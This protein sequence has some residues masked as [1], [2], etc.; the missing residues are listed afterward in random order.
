MGTPLISVAEAEASG[1]SWDQLQT[2]RWRR[3]G[4]GQYAPT[5]VKDGPLLRLTAVAKRLPRGAAFAG[6][7]AAWLH[8]IDLPPCDP[9]EVATPEHIGLSTRSGVI[10]RRL[11]LAP[12]EIV[13]CRGFPTTTILRTLTDLAWRLPLIDAVAAI[14][15]ALHAGLVHISSLNER[16]IALGGRKGVRRLRR[17]VDLAEPR[18]ESPMETR[19]RLVLVLGGLPRPEAQVDLKS[20]AGDF[21]GRA[22]LYYADARLILEFDG[23]THKTSLVEDSRRQNRLIAAGYGILRFTAADVM[24]APDAVVAQV[25][26]A[27]VGSASE[28]GFE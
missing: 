24:G 9:V 15:M 4:P 10:V 22:D 6:R 23:A 20:E 7:T 5:R 11:R 28:S 26:R 19:L 3:V 2:R 8:G 14:D 1:I 18:S 12:E 25:R 13:E 27:L 16:V 21:I 17:V